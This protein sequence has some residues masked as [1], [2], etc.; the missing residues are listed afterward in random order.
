MDPAKNRSG[1]N[2][3]PQTKRS[4]LSVG[5]ILNL[6]QTV[7]VTLQSAHPESFITTSTL[8]EPVFANLVSDLEFALEA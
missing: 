3:D 5:E 1:V 2:H 4:E 8:M 7:L 6:A